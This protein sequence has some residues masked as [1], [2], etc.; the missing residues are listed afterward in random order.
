MSK[1]L[2][3]Y[4]GVPFLLAVFTGTVGGYSKTLGLGWA[5]AYVA[6]LSFVPWWLAEVCTLAVYRAFRRLETLAKF[7]VPE[8]RTSGAEGQLLTVWSHIAMTRPQGH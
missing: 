6:A 2:L 5:L 8:S 7:V 1:P 3:F 4:I